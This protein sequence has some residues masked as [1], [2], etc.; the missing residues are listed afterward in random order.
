[1]TERPLLLLPKPIIATYS[2][3]N[4]HQVSVPQR[5]TPLEQITHL[6]YQFTELQSVF[7]REQAVLQI[8]ASGISQEKT[9]VIEVKNSVDKF[10][11]AVSRIDG[12]EWLAEIDISDCNPEESK[13]CYLLMQNERALNEF[14]SLWTQWKK[15]HNNPNNQGECKF[16][17]GLTKF[18]DLFYEIENIRYW[19]EFDRLREA[20]GI[21]YLKQLS[22][23]NT[24]V[25]VQVEFFYRSQVTERRN[26]VESFRKKVEQS[27]GYIIAESECVIPDINYHALI[28]QISIENVQKIIQYYRSFSDSVTEGHSIPSEIQFISCDGVMAFASVGQCKVSTSTLDTENVQDSANLPTPDLSPIIAVFDGLPVENH[29]YLSNRIMIDDPDEWASTYPV[30]ERRHG[31]AISSLII[32]GDLNNGLNPL[33]RKIYLRPILKSYNYDGEEYESMPESNRL[34]IDLIHCAVKRLFEGEGSTSAVCPTVKIINISVGDGGRPFSSSMSPWARLLDW[35]SVK[36]NVLFVVSAGNQD[37]FD[38]KMKKEHF[39]AL[40]S[41]ASTSELIKYLYGET[42]KHSLLSPAESINAL[43]IGSIHEDSSE[44]VLH[45]KLK[46]PYSEQLPCIYSPFGFGYGRSVKPDLLY[47]GGKMYVTVDEESD[48]YV[49]VI[50]ANNDMKSGMKTAVPGILGDKYRTGFSKGTSNA[51]ALL[52]RD[53]SICYDTL[54][55]ILSQKVS[56]EQYDKYLAVLLKSMAVHGCQWGNNIPEILT[57]SLKEMNPESSPRNIRPEITRWLG[58]GVPDIK[59][60]NECTQNR[61]TFFH[62][63]DIEEGD[64]H[65]YKIPIPEKLYKI[66]KLRVTI[67]LGWMTLP[68]PLKEYRKT[69]LEYSLKNKGFSLTTNTVTNKQSKRGT[70]QHG[71]YMMKNTQTI[72]RD[73]NNIEIYIDYPGKKYKGKINPSEKY[74]LFVT[75]EATEDIQYEIGEK[76]IYELIR[77]LVEPIRVS[78]GSHIAVR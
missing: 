16:K 38:Y 43:S 65:V 25:P 13:H 76:F 12:L 23:Q 46:D 5:P 62:Y 2:S 10:Y 42:W 35:L 20:G 58:Y 36:Y 78:T 27:E 8:S 45:D 3:G 30:E 73:D 70:M 77:E 59:R 1:M 34:G 18:R 7:N 64:S 44:K 68:S 67:T 55:N 52:S 53:L 33:S 69:S 49:Y 28:A 71:I 31:T 63:G 51:A 54:T 66:T 6:D 37:D 22:K 39:Q 61:V 11:N 29:P 32:Q 17:R 75:I 60:V 9:L 57:A 26:A 47:F 50:A 56:N 21:E 40:P 72:S 14:Y 48:K 19:N 24:S 41:E 4:G 74:G 15:F